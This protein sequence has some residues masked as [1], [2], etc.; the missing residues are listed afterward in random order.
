MIFVEGIP[1]YHFS[2]FVGPCRHVGI[3][4]YFKKNFIH[5]LHHLLGEFNTSMFKAFI[6]YYLPIYQKMIICYYYL[7]NY[8]ISVL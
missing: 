4:I 2:F 8:F 6:I 3:S 1:C 7:V 5:P